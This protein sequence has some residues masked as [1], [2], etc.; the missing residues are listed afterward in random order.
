[1]PYTLRV[2]RKPIQGKQME[3][4]KKLLEF[5]KLLGVQGNGA[6]TRG[7]LNINGPVTHMLQFETLSEIQDY[8]SRSS[9]HSE[10][11][12]EMN[13]LSHN[14]TNVISERIKQPKSPLSRGDA[15]FMMQ[16]WFTAK[17]GKRAELA[18]TL[19]ENDLVEGAVNSMIGSF[20]AGDIV[21]SNAMKN[22]DEIPGILEMGEKYSGLM[23]EL[24]PIVS[25]SSRHLSMLV[26]D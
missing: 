4:E 24:E 22:L 10:K 21:V 18:K 25:S 6:L 11:I 14:F 5:R 1:M 17:F 8:F 15:K 9:E 19:I 2:F 3:L 23:K 26:F 16:F 7:Y 12:I 13:E 20:P